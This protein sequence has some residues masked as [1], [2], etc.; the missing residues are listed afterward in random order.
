MLKNKWTKRGENGPRGHE[1]LC[2]ILWF[3]LII[4]GQNKIRENITLKRHN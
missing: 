4:E 1:T 3:W 2:N